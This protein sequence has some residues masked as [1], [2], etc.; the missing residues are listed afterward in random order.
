MSHRNR[1]VRLTVWAFA[2]VLLTAAGLAAAEAGTTRLPTTGTPGPVTTPDATVLARQTA[3]IAELFAGSAITIEQSLSP[4]AGYQR[5]VV[6]YRSDTFKIYALM[7]VP[8]GQRPDHGWP[9]IVFNHGYIPAKQYSTIDTYS[10]HVDVF[11]RHGYIVF[12]SDYRGFAA[13]EGV[14]A[15]SRRLFVTDILN[16]IQALKGLP[17]VD[18]HRIGMWGH[19]MGGYIT[20]AVMLATKDVK[21]GVIWAGT[22][23]MFASNPGL[24]DLSGPLQ[25]QQSTSDSMVS[26]RNSAELFRALRAVRLPVELYSYQ[27]DDHNLDANGTL[28]LVRSLYF[29]DRY[30]KNA[31]D[32]G[33]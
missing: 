11:A 27:N 23:G 16:A 29:F 30:V 32:G 15:R 26:Y 10:S 28:A 6:S 24:K 18:S 21:A 19:S 8:S 17:F 13:S 3:S 12:K 5:Y 25:L 20:M 31:T 33:Q 1:S 7:T 14:A 2:L 4:G 22:V 9:V